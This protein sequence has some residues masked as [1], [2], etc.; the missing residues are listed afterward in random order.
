MYGFVIPPS[1]Y[2]RLALM[3]NVLI[4][5]NNSELQQAIQLAFKKYSQFEVIT[6][7][8]G[9]EAFDI[10]KTE[11]VSIVV[12]DL[13]MP[14]MNGF[15]LIEFMNC[16]HPKIPC[17]IMTGYGSPELQ[18]R[19]G[20]YN[21]IYYYLEKPFKLSKLVEVILDALIFIEQGDGL[22]GLSL[23]GVLQ[24]VEVENK[25]FTLEVSAPN[26][27]SGLFHFVEGK[28]YS[29]ECSDL[30]CGD[31]K[32]EEA[33]I[34]MIAWD[35]VSIR[36][37]KP[38]AENLENNINLSLINIILEGTRRKD[39]IAAGKQAEESTGT[40]SSELQSDLDLKQLAIW[41]AEKNE[42]KKAQKLFI[43]Y[44]RAHPKDLTGWIWLSRIADNMK[45]KLVILQ[46]ASIISAKSVHV[47]RELRRLKLARAAGC[48]EAGVV[49][50]CPFCWTP[51][52]E[53]FAACP[54]CKAYLV[55]EKTLFKGNRNVIQE[56]M[57]E[58]IHRYIKIVLVEEDVKALYN[59]SLAYLNLGKWEDA[60]DPLYKIRKLV[61]SDSFYKQQ[62][63]L[64]LDHMATLDLSTENEIEGIALLDDN[65]QEAVRKR[66]LVVE[67][68]ATT[69]KV[70][71]I[72][73]QQEGIEVI[74]AKDGIE[75]LAKF[76]ELIPDLV[77]LD[78]IMPGVDG[79]QVLATMK[80]SYSL[81]KIPVIMLTSRD[82]LF[83]RMKGK[84][85]RSNEYLTKPFTPELLMAKVKKYL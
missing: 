43:S 46:N 27:G 82:S 72:I 30:K 54:Y 15:E 11:P 47:V 22:E 33:A 40:I 20:K 74:E 56:M 32:N 84:M 44:L 24:L 55:I 52:L 26:Q 19:L 49:L 21:N 23:V 14:K 78:I 77:L 42:M 60:L 10:I 64:L 13:Y 75:A 45:A 38:A 28:L 73:L 50:N 25:S 29:A 8:N 36:M 34:A 66:V 79:Y 41:K 48:P 68:S 12:T 2:V 6:A 59:L 57:E 81:K 7:A 5:E 67:D 31:L 9:E 76:N 80:K 83:D 1:T 4:V 3:N 61:P 85:S 37:K 69:R 51:V 39:E 16:N 71:K 63:T 62:L 70:I 53:H 35:N 17:I 65:A 18:D 58:A